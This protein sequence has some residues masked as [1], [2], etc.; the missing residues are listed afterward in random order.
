MMAELCSSFLFGF[1]HLIFAAFFFLFFSLQQRH[2]DDA[3]HNR[4]RRG[5]G[6]E[7]L[8]TEETA[9]AGRAATEI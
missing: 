6:H 3:V 4:R 7:G 9:P 5:L 8:G 1:S 2:E